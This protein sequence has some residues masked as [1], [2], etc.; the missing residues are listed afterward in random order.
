VNGEYPPGYRKT[1]SDYSSLLLRRKTLQIVWVIASFSLPLLLA[2]F[3]RGGG[4]TDLWL[5]AGLTGSVVDEVQLAAGADPVRYA[6]VVGRGLYRSVG[7][8][9]HWEP[10]NSGLPFDGL[11][12]VSVHVFAVDP[13]NPLVL[14]AGRH[15]FGAE[16]SAFSAG[17]YSTD[18]GGATW[19][20]SDQLFAGKAVQAIDV[21][22][23]PTA[24]SMS[25]ALASRD[26]SGEV[27]LV[28][29]AAGGEVYRSTDGGRAW[30][31][32]NWRGVETAILCLAIH[33][34]NPDI[35]YLGTQGGGV[36]G[37]FDGGAS[38]QV[39]NSGL[40][41]LTVHD[42]AVAMDDT[43]VMY[44]ATDDGVYCS[45]DAGLT[46][47]K[48]EGPANGRVVNAVAVHPYD[49][50]FLCAG[51]QYGGVHCT[52]DGG[53]RWMALKRGLGNLTV[54]SLALD[55][56]EPATL[57]VG[58]VDGVW[59]Y[60]FEAPVTTNSAPAVSLPTP[61][62]SATYAQTPGPTGAMTSTPK[63]SITAL[64]T[65][66][67]TATATWTPT[68]PPTVSP[69]A[70]GTA[71]P[72]TTPLPTPTLTFTAALPPPPTAVPPTPTRTPVLR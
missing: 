25:P 72:S 68:L 67:P 38:W 17:L 31:P 48:L 20:V 44:L 5:R 69:T 19:L 65:R 40:D 32:L 26:G 3:V 52:D 71:E 7:G 39:L 12:R 37:T 16:D 51:L 15:D 29:V 11:G 49:G 9:T 33:P 61:I 43:Q 54:L 42:I 27:G 62:S 6:L 64:L 47:I 53:A 13:N 58:T 55:P 30:L 1:P 56:P 45:A 2:A 66:S 57:W 63:R 28:C 8:D 34:H 18:D 41:D 35:V 60:V 10:A 4:S 50:D 23:W 21:P 70:T 24:S 14:Y 59:Q 46:W 36:Y 22:T